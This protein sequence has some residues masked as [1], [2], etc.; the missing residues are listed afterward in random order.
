MLWI[1]RF[2]RVMVIM[3]VIMRNSG[4]ELEPAPLDPARREDLIGDVAEHVGVAVHDDDLE[5]VVGAE[6]HVHRRT[7]L[8]AELVLELGEALGEI[9]DVMVINERERADGVGIRR[10]L[11]ARHFSA[12]EIAQDLRARGVPRR[13]DTI[14][15][16]EQIGFHR[17]AE[18]SELHHGA[19]A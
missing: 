10:S 8:A 12:H 4:D 15:V 16:L 18:T 13:D 1:P 19:I 3:R 6:V 17:D 7:D 14:E 2:V 9:A 5:A 11:F